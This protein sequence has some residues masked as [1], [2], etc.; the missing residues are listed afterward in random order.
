MYS[1]ESL[2]TLRQRID[3]VDV[4][5]GFLDLK[6]SGASYKALC[7]FHEEKSPSFMVQ[8]GDSHY[9]C[10]GCG[11]HGDAIQ[12]LMERQGYTFVEAIESLALKFGVILERVESSEAKGPSKKEMCDLLLK[13]ADLYHLWLIHTDKGQAA[14]KYLLDRGIDLEFIKRYKIGLAPDQP[15]FLL[16]FLQKEHV[17]LELMKSCGLITDTAKGN[18]RDFFIDRITFPIHSP[19]GSVIGFS[20]RK[21]KEE[22]Y[23]G[24]YINSVET[25]I[26]KKSHVLFG[27]NYSRPR[28]VKEKRALIVEGQIDALRLID[29]G[30]DLAVAALGTA[31]GVSH[32]EELLKLGVEQVHLLF[33][34]DPAGKEAAVKVGNLF[35]KISIDVHVVQMPEGDDPD[36]FLKKNG[37]EALL[38]LLEKAPDYLT[39]LVSYY[40]KK[41]NLNSPAE[42][43][44]LIEHL[45]Q[46]IREWDSQIMVHESLKKLADLLNVPENLVTHSAQPF[47]GYKYKREHPVGDMHI[48]PDQILEGDLILWYIKLFPSSDLM[49]PLQFLTEGH[50][51]DPFCRALF[52]E[53]TSALKSNAPLDL[54]K[55]LSHA[56]TP[57]QQIFFTRLLKKKIHI[58]KK[59]IF[60]TG[61]VQKLIDRK[62]LEEREEIRQKLH[63]STTSEEEALRLAK[64]FDALKQAP[65]FAL[66]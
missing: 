22:T 58:E 10:F 61:A 49:K 28:I 35:Q 19:T 38:E 14:L 6:R 62:R 44:Q 40:S 64:Q 66:D 56:E 18:L 1:K 46:Q 60:F 12:F 29:N 31:F 41:I 16:R 32:V 45:S 52:I 65:Q 33:D 43:N 17:E 48:N 53:L 25:P 57:E 50:F 54:I 24:K 21:Y 42:K 30:L 34:S 8:K 4:L 36:S 55:L 9:H 5:E 3:L 13:V 20:A 27:L 26:F 47:L 15:Q 11:A 2:E 37:I 7:P 59:G 23:G 63:S 39:F 51:K